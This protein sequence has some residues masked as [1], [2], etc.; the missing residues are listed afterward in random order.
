MMQKMSF[1]D[2]D[3][4]NECMEGTKLI[5]LAHLQFGCGAEFSRAGLCVEV[6]RNY[7]ITW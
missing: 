4:M 5:F 2:Q 6:L 7:I 3:I 1:V